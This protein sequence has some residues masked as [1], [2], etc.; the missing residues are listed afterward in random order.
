ML[1]VLTISVVDAVNVCTETEK[2]FVTSAKVT[3]GGSQ[4][5]VVVQTIAVV[6]NGVRNIT[7]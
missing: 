5:L 6:V 7:Y 1:F 3:D 2:L 4:R